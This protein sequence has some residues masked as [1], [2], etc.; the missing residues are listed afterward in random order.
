MPLTASRLSASATQPPSSELARSYSRDV[1]EQDHNVGG[2]RGGRV[3][4]HRRGRTSSD[5]QPAIVRMTVRAVPNY[6]GGPWCWAA[7]LLHEGGGV[8]VV[9]CCAHHHTSLVR[10]CRCADKPDHR[11]LLSALSFLG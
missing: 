6:A 10:A 7:G 9:L 4:L 2:G 11:V 1:C 5:D 8:G 3:R